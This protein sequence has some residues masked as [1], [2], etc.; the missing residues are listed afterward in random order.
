MTHATI[1]S[2]QVRTEGLLGYLGLEEQRR[3]ARQK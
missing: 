2:M 1:R 3:V